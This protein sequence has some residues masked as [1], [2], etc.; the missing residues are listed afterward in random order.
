MSFYLFAK[1][2]TGTEISENILLFHI[3]IIIIHIIINIIIE[4]INFENYFVTIYCG[5]TEV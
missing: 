2:V 5:L 3:I 4:L 1:N